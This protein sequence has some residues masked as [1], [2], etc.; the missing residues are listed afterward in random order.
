M[1]I[2][3]TQAFLAEAGSKFVVAKTA[4]HDTTYERLTLLGM[5]SLVE[6]ADRVLYLHTKGVTHQ[7][8][9]FVDKIRAWRTM[10]EYFIMAKHADC[11][12]GLETHDAVGVNWS[13][14]PA[15]HFSGNM[16]WCRGD[17]FLTLDPAALE[18]EY[19]GSTYLAPEMFIGTGNPRVISLHKSHTNHY[20]DMYPWAAFCDGVET[21]TP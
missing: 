21:D 8:K 10:M 2:E 1:Y 5:L 16:W 4:P 18:L 7:K 19:R 14:D 20:W 15:L 17:Y 11:L 13:T 12:K 3:C 6:P 9:D